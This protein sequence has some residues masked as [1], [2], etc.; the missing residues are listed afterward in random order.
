MGGKSKTIQFDVSQF[1]VVVAELV[2]SLAPEELEGVT[3][4]AIHEHRRR[5][6]VA[7]RAY[8]AWCGAKDQKLPD[9]RTVER[10]RRDYL[11]ASLDNHSQM[12][13]VAALVDQLGCV[14]EIAPGIDDRQAKA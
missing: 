7:E 11:R 5:L 1:S 3:I 6:D 10:L 13:V 9:G 14:P 4:E 2:A 12:A 8:E